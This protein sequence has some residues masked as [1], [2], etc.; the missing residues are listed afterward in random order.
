MKRDPSEGVVSRVRVYRKSPEAWTQDELLAVRVLC[1]HLLCLLGRLSWNCRSD[2][3]ES[4][5][6]EL[7]FQKTC[8][9]E[10]FA[11]SGVLL[12]T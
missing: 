6:G 5:F 10:R 4:P 1:Q 9:E 8:M 11:Q 12:A 7:G 3:L 2:P